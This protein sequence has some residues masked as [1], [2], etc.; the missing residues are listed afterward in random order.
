MLCITNNSIKHQSFVYMHQTS[1]FL[2]IQFSISHLF[3][4][5]LN[6]KQ[7]YLTHRQNPIRC[8]HSRPKWTWKQW[9]RRSTQ[10]FWSLNMRLFSVIYRTLIGEEGLTL[11]QRWSQCILPH[12]DWLGCLITKPNNQSVLDQ[13]S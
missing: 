4:Y 2:T 6:V 7:F 11:L 10:H 9:Q 3:A 8:Y 13:V 5:S 1:S 12:P